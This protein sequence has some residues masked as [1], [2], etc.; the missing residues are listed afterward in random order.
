MTLSFFVSDI[1]DESTCDGNMLNQQL[2]YL[3]GNV[4]RVPS[5]HFTFAHRRRNGA[6]GG[7][8]SG[9]RVCSDLGR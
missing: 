8:V 9:V 1:L 5:Q 6:E 4:R 7:R 3:E 2:C